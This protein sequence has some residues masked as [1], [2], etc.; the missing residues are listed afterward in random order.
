MDCTRTLPERAMQKADDIMECAA[1][2]IEEQHRHDQSARET[3]ASSE[4]Q[5]P[6]H[7]ETEDMEWEAARTHR[8][9]QAIHATAK[10]FA[11]PLEANTPP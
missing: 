5:T 8:P 2:L 3:E 7:I 11:H 4:T 9:G 6:P 1:D 10:S